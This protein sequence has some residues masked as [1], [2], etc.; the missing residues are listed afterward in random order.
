MPIGKTVEMWV[1]CD[2]CE[3]IIRYEPTCNGNVK[4]L[5]A[6]VRKMGWMVKKNGEVICPVCKSIGGYCCEEIT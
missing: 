2:R 5:T 3:K 4:R 6:E 1:I